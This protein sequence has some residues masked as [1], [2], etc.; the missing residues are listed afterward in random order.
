MCKVTSKYYICLSLL[1]LVFA[2][3]FV[4]AQVGPEITVLAP[5]NGSTITSSLANF[6]IVINDANRPISSVIVMVNGH[7]YKKDEPNLRNFR[8]DG[9]FRPNRIGTNN[10]EIIARNGQFEN[11]RRITINWQPTNPPALRR[12]NLYILAVG[13][14]RYDNINSLSWCANDARGIVQAFKSQEGLQYNQVYTRLIA[15][16]ESILPTA[17]NIRNNLQFLNQGTVDDYYLLFFSGHG[18]DDGQGGFFFYPRDYNS[19]VSSS[20]IMSNEILSVLNSPG[21]RMIFIDACHSG[22]V[23]GGR[24]IDNGRLTELLR[25]SNAMVFTASSGLE[26]SLE[27]NSLQHGAFA[28]SLI[29]SLR[30]GRNGTV[31][32]LDLVSDTTRETRRVTNGRQNP[33]LSA[34]AFEDFPIAIRGTIRPDRN[35]NP[36]LA[37]A[38]ALLPLIIDPNSPLNS[39]SN[40]EELIHGFVNWGLQQL[41]NR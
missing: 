1:I 3:G 34:L 23:I 20:R 37:L 11:R 26:T 13:V 31:T 4:S 5:V 16:G 15:D 12:P 32:M 14:N 30:E 39:S 9:S 19:W 38:Q 27:M 35:T 2:A 10:I 18:G 28:Y 7:M 40:S 21:K 17:A 8:I 41:L 29:K 22:G 24:G 25:E 33:N 36:G 6:S